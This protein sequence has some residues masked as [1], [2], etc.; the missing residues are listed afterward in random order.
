MVLGSIVDCCGI[1]GGRISI[2]RLYMVV[3][4][5]RLLVE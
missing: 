4:H 5:L 1:I 2:Q 3:E